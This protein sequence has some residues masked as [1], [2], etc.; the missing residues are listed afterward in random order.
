MYDEIPRTSKR[1]NEIES[2]AADRFKA[3]ILHN[4]VYEA[5]GQ[6]SR[7][8]HL[9]DVAERAYQLEEHNQGHTDD[10][11]RAAFAAAETLNDKIEDVVEARI[12]AE[13][14]TV[15]KD[16]RTGWFD[17]YAEDEEI[18]AAFHEACAWLAEHPDAADSAGI[19]VDGV[20]W[21]EA[22]EAAG[23]Y[24]PADYDNLS[25][26]LLEAPRGYGVED[27]LDHF[28]PVVDDDEEVTP[29]A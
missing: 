4:R 18:E 29:D 16:A 26:A 9:V 24:D 19:D 21:G 7:V 23:E 5:L 15:I 3:T 17:E 6:S 27:V 22:E 28:D 12:A 25:E 14:A 10:V 8:R 2:K 13:C 20:V 11:R 1:M